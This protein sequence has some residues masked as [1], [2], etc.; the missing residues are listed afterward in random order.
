MRRS[1][2]GAA[3]RGRAGAAADV[4]PDSSAVPHV[5]QNRPEAGAPQEGQLSTSG[6]P[7]DEQK[8]APSALAAWQAVQT[9]TQAA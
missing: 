1:A 4:G 2:A 5:L 8:F 3:G 9:V 7:H 6:L